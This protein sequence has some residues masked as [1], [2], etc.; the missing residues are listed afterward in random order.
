MTGAPGRRLAA[1]TL[2]L[3]SLSACQSGGTSSPATTPSATTT[4]SPR[5]L[6]EPSPTGEVADQCRAV[7]AALPA[8]VDGLP[9]SASTTFTAQWGG[10]AV[11][12]RCGVPKPAALQTTSP[13]AVINNVGW[14]SEQH[15]DEWVFTTIGRA[16]Y[17]EVSVATSLQPA[18]NALVDLTG[19]VSKMREVKP[20][21]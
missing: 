19:A 10:D 13:C 7:M 11:A 8:T 21:V 12:L 16:G 9:K 18:S 20:C 14:L 1:A 5:A 3:I 2:A 6:V 4:S 17:I 15:P